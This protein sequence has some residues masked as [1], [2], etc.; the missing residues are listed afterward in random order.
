M[1][2]PQGRAWTEFGNIDKTGHN[3]GIGLAHRIPELIRNL[4]L[5]VEG[6]LDVGWQEVRIVTDHGWLLM[7]KGLPK[8]ELP[9]YLT[10]TAGVDVRWSRSLRRST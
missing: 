3:E 1:G 2:D 9:K 7:P 5:R 6:L 10:A 4:V 8:T